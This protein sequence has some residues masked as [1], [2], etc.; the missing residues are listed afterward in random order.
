G[1][2]MDRVID[3]EPQIPAQPHP[4][5]IDSVTLHE[6][7]AHISAHLERLAAGEEKFVPPAWLRVTRDEPR[8]PGALAG[9]AAIGRQLVVPHSLAFTPHWLLPGLEFLLLLVIGAFR[10]TKVDRRSTY[11]RVLGLALVVAASIAMAT[12]A[13]HL[14]W[15]LIH[16]HTTSQDGLGTAGEL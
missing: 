16:R 10:Q 12:S 2:T 13:G 1:H 5:E 15:S 9:P 14:V 4:H 6:K 3:D 11:L 8:L 7:L